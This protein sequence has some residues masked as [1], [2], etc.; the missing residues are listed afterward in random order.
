[1]IYSESVMHQYVPHVGI[2]GNT[3]IRPNGVDDVCARIGHCTDVA[4]KPKSELAKRRKAAGFTQQ[5]TAEAVGTTISMYG[6]LE[7]G[8]RTMNQRWLK[9]LCEFLRATPTDLLGESYD[10]SQMPEEPEDEEPQPI[11]PWL[12]SEATLQVIIRALS[13]ALPEGRFHVA[14]APRFAHAWRAALEYFAADRDRE[15]N[16]DYQAG[17]VPTINR[18][19]RDY[20]QRHEQ[21]A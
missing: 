18:A 19:L 20:T 7:R 2:F 12:P 16:E 13:N 5:Q 14:D 11:V 8:D 6:K 4:H 1:M 15:H 3:K 17:V 9:A 10:F 21:A